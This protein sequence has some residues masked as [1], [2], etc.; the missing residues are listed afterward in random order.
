MGIRL[1][2][3]SCYL[4]QDLPPSQG[5][6]SASLLLPRWAEIPKAASWNLTPHRS[7]T[8]ASSPP[9]PQP[10][11]TF[12]LLFFHTAPQAL[13][14]AKPSY[15]LSA[16]TLSFSVTL[17]KR[18]MLQ[19]LKGSLHFSSVD[20]PHSSLSCNFLG[21]CSWN[22]VSSFSLHVGVSW[23]LPWATHTLTLVVFIC[24]H[25]LICNP[26]VPVF[27]N[28]YSSSD[29]SLKLPHLIYPAAYLAS[30]FLVSRLW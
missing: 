19:L 8:L 10:P 21:S 18:H 27:P 20:N 24:T 23:A 14:V 4:L 25:G 1:T 22:W 13:H 7:S 28:F 2:R 12:T 11:P 16:L 6:S 26:Y 29:L 15:N 9:P 3:Q 17:E 30:W 5:L